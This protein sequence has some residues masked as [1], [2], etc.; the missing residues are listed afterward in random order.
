MGIAWSRG[1]AHSSLP[2]YKSTCENIH[3][4]SYELRMIILTKVSLNHK[5][6]FNGLSSLWTPSQILIA[7]A[8]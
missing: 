5:R 8:W 4:T 2:K 3:K 1:L 6:G 7:R